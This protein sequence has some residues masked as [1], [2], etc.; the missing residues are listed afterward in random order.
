M[1]LRAWFYRTFSDPTAV[2]FLVLLIVAF[3]AVTFLAQFLEPIIAGIVVAY[4]L[5]GF[6]SRLERKLK[7]RLTAV[8]IVFAVFLSTF[9]F[10]QLSVLP[11]L[12]AQIKEF[13]QTLPGMI[14]WLQE[15][16]VTLSEMYPNLVSDSDLR[17][18]VS[19]TRSDIVNIGQTFVTIS[20]NSLFKVVVYLFL[21]PFLVFFLLKDKD[22]IIGGVRDLYPGDRELLGRFWMDVDRQIG[23]YVRGKFLEIL[24]VWG[25]SGVVFALLGLR[26]ALLLG[27][28]VGISVLIPYIGVAV[29]TIPVGLVA[30]FQWGPS[31]EFLW[32]MGAYAVIQILDGN[33]LSPLLLSEV[34]D[35]HPVVIIGAILLFGGIW[36]FWGVFF[37]VPLTTFIRA[38]VRILQQRKLELPGAS[39]SETDPPQ[40]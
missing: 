39:Q 35:L 38:I 23:A 19:A 29:M 40:E 8:L 2:I 1:P 31:A 22:L 32:V 4:L 7:S 5:E 25:V 15:G 27:F 9:L 37:A 34:V 14:Q 3:A 33:V 13:L 11:L 26:V 6:V 17:E 10:L 21:V 30:F 28:L 20:V 24:I 16:L 12:L 36:G 18:I